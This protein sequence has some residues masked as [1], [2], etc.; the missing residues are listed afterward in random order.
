MT[1]PSSGISSTSSMATVAYQPTAATGASQTGSRTTASACIND[2]LPIASSCKQKTP[3][4]TITSLLCQCFLPQEEE[5]KS[6]SHRLPRQAGSGTGRDKYS[7]SGQRFSS[8]SEMPTH[9]SAAPKMAI[10]FSDE[11]HEQILKRF[12]ELGVSYSKDVLDAIFELAN[13]EIQRPTRSSWTLH[14]PSLFI[15]IKKSACQDA[16]KYSNLPKIQV[17]IDQTTQRI[18]LFIKTTPSNKDI[19]STKKLSKAL[20]LSFMPEASPDACMEIK[21]QARLSAKHLHVDGLKREA[22]LHSRLQKSYDTSQPFSICCLDLATPK[23]AGKANQEKIVLYSEYC[24][25]GDLFAF[26]LKMIEN[27]KKNQLSTQQQKVYLRPLIEDLIKAV[28][29]FHQEMES[30]DQYVH[31]DIKPENFFVRLENNKYRLVLGDLGTAQKTGQN[32][33]SGKTTP[34]YTCE[35]FK[36]RQGLIK[37]FSTIGQPADIWAL[38]CCIYELY[39]QRSPRWANLL[40]SYQTF[41]SLYSQA[42]KC[43]LVTMSQGELDVALKKLQRLTKDIASLSAEFLADL[44]FTPG[45]PSDKEIHERAIAQKLVMRGLISQSEALVKEITSNFLSKKATY[46]PKELHAA[47]NTVRQLLSQKILTAWDVLEKM[48]TP[49]PDKSKSAEENFYEALIW[50]MLRPDPSARINREGLLKLF[51]ELTD[52]SDAAYFTPSQMS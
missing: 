16:L 28:A 24:E 42:S 7:Y 50:V 21:M 35:L 10:K 49:T 33:I 34:E 26:T 27:F 9:G 31:L 2:A 37:D 44:Q 1:S 19:G 30:K 29:D 51:A 15:N 23:Y 14:G 6:A 48:P 46:F 43:T 8:I 3:T 38:G 4:T 13:A 52:I 45:V 18:Q 17:H 20:C 40:S 22:D 39:M 41:D 47:L 12:A 5:S 32:F 11:M 25:G 36:Y